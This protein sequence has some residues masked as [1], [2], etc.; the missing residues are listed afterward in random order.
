MD[1]GNAAPAYGP[2]P[3]AVPAESTLSTIT[4]RVRHI[5]TTYSRE[6]IG[7]LLR[8]ALKLTSSS[9]LRVGSIAPDLE[10]EN[11][12]VATISF[13]GRSESLPIRNQK[14]EKLEEW[15]VVLKPSEDVDGWN[16]SEERVTIDTHFRDFTPL[17]RPKDGEGAFDL[18]A[19]SGLGGHA[20]GSFKQRDGEYMWLRDGIPQERTLESIRVIIYGYDSRMVGSRDFQGLGAIAST[21]KNR[22]KNLRRLSV[23]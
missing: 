23:R 2:A 9:R 13:H 11:L 19:V 18:I 22:L 7:D 4:Y 15:T 21:F 1:R 6:E 8:T 5:P 3:G 12:Q 17:N 10:N 14:H 16:I 20:F